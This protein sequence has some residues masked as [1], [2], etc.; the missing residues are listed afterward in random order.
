MIFRATL[1]L[2]ALILIFYF[3]SIGRRHPIMAAGFSFSFALLFLFSIVPELSTSMAQFV[4][5]G[6]GVDLAIYIAIVFLLTFTFTLYLG[7]REHGSQLSLL[8]RRVARDSAH[9]SQQGRI[10]KRAAIIPMYQE[11]EVIRD[12]LLELT[13]LGISAIVVDDGS[14]DQSAQEVKQLIEEGCSIL[15]LEHPINLGQGA[16]LMTGFAEARAL[17]LSAVVTFDS[18]GQ[19][20]PKDA[21]RLLEELE[22]DESLDLILGSRFLG[23][24]EGMPRSRELMLKLAIRFTQWTGGPKLSDSHNGL[25]AIRGSALNQLE[26]TQSR[27][28]H[29]SELLQLIKHHNLRYRESPVTIRYTDRSLEKGQSMWGAINIVR[30]LILARLV[31]GRRV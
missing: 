13:E 16:A 18:D 14:I 6:R 15:L 4:G 23:S 5:I 8:A 27:M 22:S 7:L 24:T 25:R 17:G 31:R 11:E 1:A 20:C 2:C 29:A 10:G 19:H 3:G 30:D 21:L 26:L 9:R 28:A 12:V